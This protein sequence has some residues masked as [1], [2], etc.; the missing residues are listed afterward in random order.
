MNRRSRPFYVAAAAVIAV[1]LFGAGV[2]PKSN[3][4]IHPES[5]SVQAT[6]DIDDHSEWLGPQITPAT[7]LLNLTSSLSLSILPFDVGN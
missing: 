7:G 6:A 3:A 4:I 1:G 2:V 5:V